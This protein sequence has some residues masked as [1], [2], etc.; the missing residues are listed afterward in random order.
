MMTTC[1]KPSIVL[2][3]A[4]LW[5]IVPA[6]SFGQDIKLNQTYPNIGSS[7][8]VHNNEIKFVYPDS[9][10]IYILGTSR[11]IDSL[12]IVFTAAIDYSGNIIWEKN[13]DIPPEWQ[14]V[15]NGFHNLVR[16]NPHTFVAGGNFKQFPLP[17]GQQVSEPF[18]YYFSPEG[19]SLNFITL[20]DTGAK[21]YLTTLSVNHQ[22]ELI[23]AGTDSVL[24]YTG[25][26]Y[27]FDYRDSSRNYWFQCLNANGVT[28]HFNKISWQDLFSYSGDSTTPA[29]KLMTIWPVNGDSINYIANTLIY[30]TP[31]GLSLN[32]ELDSNLNWVGRFI[33][34]TGTT[35]LNGY[36]SIDPSRFMATQAFDT[37]LGKQENNKIALFYD[38]LGVISNFNNS[39]TYYGI[40]LCRVDSPQLDLPI[41]PHGS[42]AP[43]IFIINNNWTSFLGHPNSWDNSEPLPHVGFPPYLQKNLHHS[44]LEMAINGD[45][46]LE[47]E[48]MLASDSTNNPQWGYQVPML[49]RA[50]SA[51]GHIKW[52][53]PVQ[54]KPTTDTSVDQHFNDM[55]V[56]PNGCLM[57]GG[58]V[59][60]RQPVAGYDSTGRHSWLVMLCDSVHDH[61]TNTGIS[62]PLAGDKVQVTVYPNPTIDNT[63]I[64]LQHFEGRPQD[65]TWQLSDLGGRLLE[66]GRMSST[67]EMIKLKHYTTGIY[68]LRVSYKGKPVA[69][70]EILK[71]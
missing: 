16:L 19:D 15:I 47:R 61:N 49:I 51:D 53:L 48:A 44:H 20:A 9:N 57:L 1:Y 56:A 33:I 31:G 64:T 71:N 7:S 29:N 50:D 23:A 67:K 25:P 63:M 40:Y 46:L 13:L 37:Y 36:M 12:P 26:L 45:L 5:I 43:G 14:P 17:N 60:V 30:G 68:M 24:H 70:L 62:V 27:T 35:I 65:F 18:L 42:Y 2:L 32:I 3:L 28:Q 59:N 8:L 52:N 69:G 41:G 39:D 54:Y 21:R 4:A 66:S 11:S 6:K 34:G 55:M 22:G 58:Y 10:R 38:G